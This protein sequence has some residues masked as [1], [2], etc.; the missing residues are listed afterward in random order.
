MKSSK[1]SLEKL[2]HFET[3]HSLLFLGMLCFI[4]FC[5]FHSITSSVKCSA[6][7][8]LAVLLFS[9]IYIIV[10]I[11]KR[12]LN[13]NKLIF[14]VILLG[15]SLRLA[16]LLYNDIYHIQY[17][18]VGENGHLD[19]ILYI[20][21]HNFTLPNFDVTKY[22]QFYQP[23]FM[24]IISALWVKLQMN[25]GISKS[26]ALENIQYISLFCSSAIMVVTYKIIKSF[27]VTKI[28][29]L[30]STAAVAF[31]PAYIMFAGQIN[32]DILSTMF[33]LIAIE[34]TIKWYKSR[35]TGQIIVIALCIGFGMLTK[36][37][38][39]MVAPAI[40]FI[41]LYAF[42]TSKNKFEYI[43]S[44]FAIISLPIGLFWSIR[45]YI[46]WQVPFNYVLRL[47]KGSYL[48]ISNYSIAERLFDFSKSHFKTASFILESD[49]VI[50]Q[51]YNP[52]IALFKTSVFGEVNLDFL[53]KYQFLGLIALFAFSLLGIFGFISMIITFAN[54]KKHYG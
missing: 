20:L 33:A 26:M 48:D 32:N 12:K 43:N 15:F 27:E 22:Y 29:L 31:S 52:T 37:S 13:C 49:P 53:G 50:K 6:I 2:R 9:A 5:V 14:V 18:V 8:F 23:P 11:A 38:V 3:K 39:W 4:S 28:P 1:L 54:K 17:D 46:K 36:L 16:Y 34:F 19:Y 30:I 35:K 24:H 41:F 51:D 7:E 45:N 25:V 42:F 10:N 21:N 47:P 44:I 40:A